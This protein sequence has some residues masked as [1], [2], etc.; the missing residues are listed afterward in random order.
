MA[1]LTCEFTNQNC[2]IMKFIS[3]IYDEIFAPANAFDPASDAY[4]VTRVSVKNQ[5]NKR[6]EVV[7]E[8]DGGASNTQLT[9]VDLRIPSNEGLG[10]RI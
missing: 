9:F 1:V 6:F 4:F 10:I 3:K 8:G 5:T 2:R 7:F